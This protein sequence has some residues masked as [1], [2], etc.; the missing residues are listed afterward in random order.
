MCNMQ[1]LRCGTVANHPTCENPPKSGPRLKGLIDQ[2]YQRLERLGHGGIAVVYRAKDLS[3]GQE[4]ALKVPRD[5]R[6][7]NPLVRAIFANQIRALSVCRDGPGVLQ[8]LGHGMHDG[9][10]YIV[11]ERIHGRELTT[12]PT[13]VLR[14]FSFVVKVFSRLCESLQYIHAA[15]VVHRDVKPENVLVGDIPGGNPTV[16]LVDFDY[17]KVPNYPDYAEIANHPVGTREFLSPEQA[18]MQPVDHRSDLYS[19][20]V[21]MYNIVTFGYLPFDYV[22]PDDLIEKHIRET[23][24]PLQW[25]TMRTENLHPLFSA[26]VGMNLEKSPHNRFQSAQQL[27]TALESFLPQ[28]AP[29]K[30]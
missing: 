2:R 17:A 15:G 18:Q 28:A 24:I 20:A 8:Y 11:T 10:P 5:D 9:E 25:R 16:K 12:L 29:E 13:H 30:T 21:S 23:P 26:V 6:R 3:S 27:K 19:L 22:H 14:S 4:V 7:K 1:R